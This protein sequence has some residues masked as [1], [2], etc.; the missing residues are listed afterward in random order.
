MPLPKHIIHLLSGG[1]D[2]TVLLYDLIGQQ[3]QVHCL[4]IDYGQ[5]HVKELDFAILHCNRLSVPFTRLSLP[6]LL[7][8]SLT[9]GN[10]SVV[11]PF[12]NAIFLAYAVNIATAACAEAVTIGC[13]KTDETIF[14]DCRMAFMQTFSR[15]CQIAEMPIEICA[16]YID[17]PKSWIAG[18]GREIGVPENSTWS[19]YAGGKEPCGECGACKSNDV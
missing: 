17:K 11:V 6:Q 13:N 7:G 19:C 14:P 12:R 5:T 10:G 18:L 9:T 1:L 4:L 3:V 16:P 15:L 8:S 2:S